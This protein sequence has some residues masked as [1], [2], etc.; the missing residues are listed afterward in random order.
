M[1]RIT[2]LVVLLILLLGGGYY[3]FGVY[4]DQRL[5]AA[6]DQSLQKLPPGYSASYTSVH[7]SLLTRHGSIRGIAI[8]HAAPNEFSLMVDRLAV[9]HPSLDLAN[10]WSRSAATPTSVTPETALPVAQGITATGVTL[11]TARVNSTTGS[12]TIRGPRVYPWALLRPDLPSISDALKTMTA[13]GTPQLADLAPMLKVEGAAMLSFGYDSHVVE[14]A[15]ATGTVPATDK[16]PATTFGYDF[17]R[18]QGGSYDRG[19]SQQ[20]S[21]EAI[22]ADLGAEGSFTVDR[23][24]LDGFDFRQPATRLLAGDPLTPALADGLALGGFAYDGFTFHPPTGAPIAIGH[25]SVSNVAFAHGRPIGMEFALAKLHLTRDQVV[26]PQVIDLMRK[27][28]L[29]GLT[30]SFN[31]GY[32]WDVAKKNILIRNTSFTVDELGGLDLVADLTGMDPDGTPAIDGRL[33]HA[34]LHYHDNSLVDRALKVMAAQNGVDE[35]AL[36]DQLAMVVVQRAAAFGDS[37]ALTNAAKQLAAF[38]ERPKLLTVELS[39]AQ[40]VPLSALNSTLR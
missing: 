7:Y 6:L 16:S 25:I 32:H 30:I 27:A 28:G 11:K 38:I 33:A 20:A 19:I 35:K 40:P 21:G 29:D 34:L 15:H 5:K 2:I 3:G 9:D 23:I 12:I 14:N 39:P 31:A 10:E 26:E 1:R 36:R 17:R 37:P 18:F 13:T 24:A 8:R 4:S 22:Q